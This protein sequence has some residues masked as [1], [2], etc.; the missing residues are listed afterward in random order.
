VVR[1]AVGALM[2]VACGRLG[3]AP[4][5]DGPTTG[6]SDTG[7]ADSGTHMAPAFVQFN[8]G[9][10]SA[11]TLSLAYTAPVTAQDLLVVA[12]GFNGSG[13]TLTS[14]TDTTGDMFTVLP[15]VA[16][17]GAGRY[18]GYAIAG[19]STAETVTAVVAGTGFLVVRVH[20]Y[21]GI[22]ATHSIDTFA[23]NT[24]TACGT[25]AATVQI[26]TA[27]DHEM[28]FAYAASGTTSSA[29][30]GYASHSTLSTGVTEDRVEPTA[31]SQLVTAS[32]TGA[33]WTMEALALIGP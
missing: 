32:C 3:F 23:T 20:E 10:V 5:S 9:S 25:D 18:V 14:L 15:K 7:V 13:G 17:S 11:G 33:P 27:Y 26:T 2:L 31:G 19:T 24:G 30:A 22:D 12:V 6:G 4:V 1:Q 29:S 28:V 16:D 21:S 8:D